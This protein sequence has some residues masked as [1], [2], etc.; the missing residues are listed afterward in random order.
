MEFLTYELAE[1]I[2]HSVCQ[3]RVKKT[4]LFSSYTNNVCSLNKAV[5]TAFS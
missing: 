4:K 1:N 3:H 5:A 2:K